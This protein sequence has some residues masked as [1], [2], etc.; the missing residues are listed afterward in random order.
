MNAHLVQLDIAWEDPGVNRE[1]IESLLERVEIRPGDLVVLPEMAF[2]GFSLDVA[3]TVSDAAAGEGFLRDLARRRSCTVVG[4]LVAPVGGRATNQAL[5][6]G[7]DGT[8]LAR[9][10]KLQPF[11]L[12]GEA[13]AH[14]AG[15]E[16][17]DFAWA[18][19]RVAPFICYDLRFPEHFRCAAA[20]GAEMFVVIANW[21]ARRIDHW[22]TLLQARAIENQATVVG[23]NRCGTDPNFPY[24]GRS[25]VVSP[26][27]HVVTD[28]G[29][30]EGVVSVAIDPEEIR[31][32]RRDFPA[33]SDIRAVPV[34]HRKDGPGR[35]LGSGLSPSPLR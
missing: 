25:V 1:R 19:L 31:Q 15:E 14:V 22:T 28:A 29:E 16:I 10:S 4:G 24:N 33:L 34:S 30:V 17:V 5:A 13:T 26:H 35:S 11:S 18:G 3:R 12:G 2:T 20:H 27:G 6:L 23:V 8:L 7:P 9:Y 21:P 32:W